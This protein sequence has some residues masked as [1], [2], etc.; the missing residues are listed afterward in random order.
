MRRSRRDRLRPRQQ[1]QALPNRRRGRLLQ[2]LRHGAL[3]AGGQGDPGRLRRDHSDGRGAQ[4]RARRWPPAPRPTPTTAAA[5]RSPCWRSPRARPRASASATRRSCMRSPATWASRARAGRSTTSPC[6][7]AEK[8]LAEFGK[9]TGELMY[10]SRATRAAPGALARGEDRPPR[11]RPRGRRDD[12]PH[13]HGRR[14][15]RREHPRPG[16]ARALERW[17]GRL[18]AR[19]RHQRH[20]VRHARL[21][22]R[23]R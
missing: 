19:H 13:P 10:L 21:R 11:H 7:V 23:A 16:P 14:P 5:W 18:D 2:A 15:G 20:P 6:E 4:L 22:C 12:A 9:Q 3:P 8:A 17:L 1:H